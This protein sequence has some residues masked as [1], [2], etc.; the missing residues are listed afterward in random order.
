MRDRQRISL[1]V[2]KD[3]EVS[4]EVLEYQVQFVL[5]RN[6]FQQFHYARVVCFLKKTHFTEGCAGHAF[7]TMINLNFFEGNNLYQSQQKCG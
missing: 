1:S 5:P 2:H 6:Y 4:V 7:V 3:F